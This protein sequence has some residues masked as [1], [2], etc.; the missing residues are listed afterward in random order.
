MN[1]ETNDSTDK[2]Q[3]PLEFSVK[4]KMLDGTVKE[5]KV[6]PELER[7]IDLKVKV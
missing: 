3:T 5:A 1:S 7:V 2:S 6:N 4:V